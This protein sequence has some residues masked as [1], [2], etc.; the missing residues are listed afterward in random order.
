MTDNVIFD[1]IDFEQIEYRYEYKHS[2]K[3][4]LILFAQVPWWLNFIIQARLGS[5]LTH[6]EYQMLWLMIPLQVLAVTKLF[7]K[8]YSR[9]MVTGSSVVEER[10]FLPDKEL[11]YSEIGSIK[12]DRPRYVKSADKFSKI[13]SRKPF[14]PT[15]NRSEYWNEITLKST[16]RKRKI[17]V[18][19]RLA[20][21][22]RFVGDLRL[23]MDFAEERYLG[24]NKGSQI[25]RVSRSQETHKKLKASGQL[26]W[27]RRVI[28]SKP[29]L[30]K[31]ND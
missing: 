20:D 22:D 17:V 21:F 2:W 6:F 5:S 25:R 19:R 7:F 29:M 13:A 15:V 27:L 11:A 30:N 8:K 24:Y 18:N 3:I 10:P 31:N 9:L 12:F 1:P 26:T 28:P 23:R 14:W 16:D 4:F